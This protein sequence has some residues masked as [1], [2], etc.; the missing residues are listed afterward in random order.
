M[1]LAATVVLFLF[2]GPFDYVSSQ[3]TKTSDSVVLQV[4]SPQLVFIAVNSNLELNCTIRRHINNL[5]PTHLLWKHKNTWRPNNSYV[6]DNYTVQLKIPHINYKDAGVYG[7]GVYHNSS[8]FQSITS[9]NVTVV[10]GE[11]PVRPKSINIKDVFGNPVQT[12][13]IWWPA[14]VN[15]TYELF[16]GRLPNGSFFPEFIETAVSTQ[17]LQGRNPN[18]LLS[19]DVK[20]E[21]LGQLFFNLS[22]LSRN[23]YHMHNC[24][25]HRCDA[26]FAY[27]IAKNAFGTSKKNQGNWNLLRHAK[28]PT[29][30]NLEVA[31]KG[32]SLI[33]SWQNP[34]L[35]WK[36]YIAYYT[37]VQNVT[38]VL[39]EKMLPPFKPLLSQFEALSYTVK[40]PEPYAKYRFSVSCRL[41]NTLMTDLG[42][43]AYIEVISKEKAPS[44]A[45][46]CVVRNRT[47]HGQAFVSLKLPPK[48]AWNGR[49]RKVIIYYVDGEQQKAFNVSLDGL[50]E[51]RPIG[52]WLRDLDPRK[53]YS[54]N[55]AMCTGGGCGKSMS[56]CFVNEV[57]EDSIIKAA[58]TTKKPPS[59]TGVEKWVV[60]PAGLLCG[61]TFSAF[62][63]YTIMRKRSRRKQQTPLAKALADCSQTNFHLYENDLDEP[64]L[65][66]ESSNYD[67]IPTKPLLK[68]VDCTVGNIYV[69]KL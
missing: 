3:E 14:K 18:G 20:G 48:A 69:S 62:I 29:P 37:L 12:L 8:R 13:T 31:F 46:S 39:T 64:S 5:H 41:D 24:G 42:P 40:D 6:V 21:V 65:C 54:F 28:C 30:A 4:N 34:H 55:V 53:N 56:R 47:I 19:Y 35:V 10:V 38:P 43:V 25:I 51:D 11:K 27:V 32:H 68:D 60:I 58:A 50:H 22:E 63:I 36:S 66:Q 61:I 7:C 15:L 23:T 52:D 16:V 45:P 44:E 26:F 49:P 1:H 9:Q 33:I 2:I 57:A 59:K 17:T 67:I